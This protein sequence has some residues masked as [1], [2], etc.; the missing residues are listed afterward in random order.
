MLTRIASHRIA[1]PAPRFG[2][3]GAAFKCE[4]RR[5]PKQEHVEALEAVANSKSSL[6]RVVAKSVQYR[7]HKQLHLRVHS[8][9]S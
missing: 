4:T 3:L 1:P 5:S 6:D 8:I 7:V 9:Y 2:L